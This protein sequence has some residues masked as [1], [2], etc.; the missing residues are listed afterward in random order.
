[1]QNPTDDIISRLAIE[2]VKTG[3]LTHDELVA[4]S[5]LLLVA[6]NATT[7]NTIV[8]GTL[9]LLQHPD[10]LAEL[11][12]DPSLIKSAVEEIL[13]YLTGS[14][15]ATRRLALEDVEI[16]GITIKK[17]EGVWALNASANEDED[18]FPNATRFDIHRQPNPQL[19][20]GDGI[21]VCVAQ[22]LARAEVQIAIGTLIRRCPNLQLAVSADELQYVTL[23]K[24][25]FGVVALPVKW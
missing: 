6:G 17:G 5:F 21:H 14:Q 15:F 12:K 1:M 19:A 20:F 10:Q 7:A 11:R 2:Q 3:K 23:A 18:V 25:D 16:G 22:D 9:T 13:R 8:L 24:R 4:M